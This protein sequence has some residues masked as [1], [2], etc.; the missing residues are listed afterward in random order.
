MNA[1]TRVEI[2]ALVAKFVAAEDSESLSAYLRR[3]FREAWNNLDAH[4]RR[5]YRD[6]ARF[7]HNCLGLSPRV[8]CGVIR[9]TVRI[10][11]WR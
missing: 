9:R 5:A 8:A 6:E 3:S 10:G 2:D 7:L 4:Q 11:A 1:D